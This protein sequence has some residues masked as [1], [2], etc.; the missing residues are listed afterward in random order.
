MRCDASPDN[1]TRLVQIMVGWTVHCTGFLFSEAAAAPPPS[2]GLWCCSGDLLFRKHCNVVMLGKKVFKSYDYRRTSKRLF[3][4]ST[5]RRDPEHYWNSDLAGLEVVDWTS[6]RDPEDRLQI[7][8]YDQ[9]P[10]VHHPSV[11]LHFILVMRK[12]AQLHAE[13]IVHGVLQG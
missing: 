1:I 9:V 6:D 13:G 4:Q 2:T 7:I 8:S 3:V 10:G 11:V 5:H 12:I